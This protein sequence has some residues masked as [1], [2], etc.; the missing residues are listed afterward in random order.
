MT[1]RGTLFGVLAGGIGAFLAFAG[2]AQATTLK[3]SI[4]NNQA[5]GGLNLTPLFFALHDGSFDPFDEGSPASGDVE[6]LA[7]DGIPSGLIAAAGSFTNGVITSPGGFAG[8]PVIDPGETASVKITVDP[9]TE[10]YLTFLS[11]VIPSNDNFIGNDTPVAYEVFDALGEYASIGAIEVF[12]GDVWDAGTEKNTGAGAAFS[13]LPGPGEDEGS[14]ITRQ[15]GLDFLL[16]TPTPAGISI[17]SVPGGRDLLATIEVSLVPIPAGMPL[18]LGGL[19]M[20]AI[21]RKRRLKK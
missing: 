16:G 19:G 5:A 2:G 10:R 21:A 9:T 18:L 17:S 4:T 20:L 15:A 6:G 11:M 7:E 12:G 1:I 3:I 13:T 14:V 8:A